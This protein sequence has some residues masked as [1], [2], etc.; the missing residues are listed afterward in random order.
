[1]QQH[2]QRRL[3][4]VYAAV[5]MAASMVVSVALPAVA[6]SSVD[7]GTVSIGT[8]ASHDVG[9]PLQY[10]LSEVPSDYIVYAGGNPTIDLALSA[11][12]LSVPLPAGELYATIGEVTATFH[13]SLTVSGSSD[14]TVDDGDCPTGSGMCAA[15]IT[16]MPTSAGAQGASIA[17]HIADLQTSGGGT[18]A[19]LISLLAPSLASSVED[20]LVIDVTGTGVDPS[21]TVN[22]QVSVPGSAA[23]IEL[24][25]TSVDFGTLPLGSED[26][27]AS[28]DITVTNCSGVDGD[29]YASGTDAD[30]GSSAH[31]TLVDGQLTCADMLG[32]DEY[33]LGLEQ[34]GNEVGLNTTNTLLESL[35]GGASGTHTARIFTACPGSTGSGATMSM[36]I[37][38]LA[39][40]GG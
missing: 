8:S 38:F 5:A 25:T 40:T 32:T 10:S 15:T 22:A 26:Q 12:G 17:A 24:S 39:T 7:L 3:L 23:C 1:M 36:Q 6:A 31:W 37:T 16:F 13:L 4:G 21:G 35:G 30:D 33:R 19:S 29:I 14:F 20:Q 2:T 11:A 18:Y 34:S 28:P 27:P 9:L